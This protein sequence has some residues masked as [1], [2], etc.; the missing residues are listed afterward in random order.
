[1]SIRMLWLVSAVALVVGCTAKE[2]TPADRGTSART[3][4]GASTGKAPAGAV[5]QKVWTGIDGN[6]VSDITQ[7]RKYPKAPDRVRLFPGF[8]YENIGNRYGSETVALVSPPGTGEYTFWL[9]SD[10][11]GELWLGS[12]STEESCRKIA[13]VRPYSG[14][15][16]WDRSPS[17]KS[18]PVALVKGRRYFVKALHKEG[19]GADHMSV[20]W[21][22][23]GIR[24]REALKGEHLSRVKLDGTVKAMLEETMRKDAEIVKLKAEVVAMVE[25]GETLPVELVK[26]LPY[27]PKLPGNDTGINILLDQAHQT[28][29]AILWGLKG[30]INRLGYRVCS[31]IATLNT[32]LEPGRPSRIRFSFKDLQPY[33]WWPNPE[34]NVVITRQTDLNAQ[35]YTNK[36]RKALKSFVESG[37]GLIIMPWT[38]RD[39]KAAAAWSMNRLAGDYGARIMAESGK[40]GG[41]RTPVLDLSGSWEVLARDGKNRPLRGRRK[42]GKGRVMMWGSSADFVVPKKADKE[43]AAARRDQMKQVMDWLA[44]GKPPVGGDPS[45]PGG[46]GVNIFPENVVKLEGINIYYASNQSKTVTD[47]LEKQVPEAYLQVRRWLPSKIFAEPYGM[48]ICAGGGGGWAIGGRPKSSALITYK[49]DGILSIMAHEVAHTIGGPRNAKGELAGRSPH[50]N[51]GEA[52]AGWFQ[53]K[54]NAKYTAGGKHIGKA[55]RGCNSILNTEK[56]KGEKIDLA[57]YDREKWGKGPDW[58][59]YWWVWQKIEDRYGATWYTRWYWVRSTRWMDEPSHKETF[60]EMVEDMSIAVGEDLFPF[61]KSIGT[62][63]K[64]DRLERIEFQGRVMKLPVAPIDTGPA[65]GVNLEEIGDY[66]KPLVYEK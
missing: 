61:F 62:T 53:G 26:R 44:K 10:D 6:N 47:C 27:T 1:M 24:E 52:H 2:V 32:V 38:P 19:G 49:P 13:H 20:A 17:Q 60:D 22:G 41:S 48:V 25:K 64:K 4:G 42:L 50:G 23:P 46:G 12:S 54:V 51:Q 58:T 57:N 45:M 36:E 15:R 11:G 59:K 30:E 14:P 63:L 34:F 35:P 7:S 56:R 29:F 16:E 3:P 8:G 33:S 39:E 37:G 9:A 18:K 65:G 31:S 21:R 5:L 43:T 28:S 55:N 66:T 40:I